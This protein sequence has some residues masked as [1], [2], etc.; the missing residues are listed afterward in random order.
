MQDSISPW[1]KRLLA[2]LAASVLVAGAAADPVV[3]WQ[4]KRTQSPSDLTAGTGNYV[5]AG[6]RPPTDPAAREAWESGLRALQAGQLDNAEEA[7]RRAAGLE[8]GAYAPVLGL[9]D[10]ALYRGRLPESERMMARARELAPKS[11]EVATASGRLAVAARRVPQAQ[12]EFMRAIALDPRFITPHLDLA[13][14]HLSG[15]NSAEAAT[16]FRAA[17]AADPQHPGAPY[18]LGRALAARGDLAG[19]VAALDQSAR[20]APKNPLPLV[21]K[22]EVQARQKQFDVA[23]VTVDK[24]LALEP[25]FRP[26]R[27]VKVDIL[28][29][30]GRL[31]TAIVEMKR[32]A[33][34][35]QGSTEAP[36]FVKLG[37]L[38]RAAKQPEA[39]DAS[40]RRAVAIDPQHHPA[41]NNIAWLG[42]EQ[43]SDL[44][45]ALSASQRALELAPG[46]AL[47][48]DTL[49]YVH[50]ARGDLT[51][52]ATAFGKAIQAAPRVPDFHFR[53]GQTLE[54][55]S[56]ADKAL[57]SYQTA[58]ALGVPFAEVD[59]ARQRVAALSAKI[60]KP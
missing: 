34:S 24:A 31:D 42:A 13:E 35:P 9:A 25:D 15:G 46:T 21:A 43:K 17:M 1:P 7:F 50:L 33:S 41:W 5:P 22:S 20:V 10:V 30:A 36:L 4:A 27:L 28:A 2:G 60:T 52:A 57:L 55:Q 38:Q 18:G 26:A 39:A 47:Y 19:A 14:L 44:D 32:L 29:A 51:Q 56:Q 23:L 54:R 40:F 45:K 48:E 53:L 11:A 16:S 8:P 3:S 12:A 37:S 59:L 6:S 49:G 58:L